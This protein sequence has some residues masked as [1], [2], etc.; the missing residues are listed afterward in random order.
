MLPDAVRVNP[1][2]ARNFIYRPATPMTEL[3]K[4]KSQSGHPLLLIPLLP[5]DF[6]NYKKSPH[7][8]RTGHH[9]A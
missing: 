4:R 3:E 7:S 8:E 6:L 9:R 5:F 2:S 1:S